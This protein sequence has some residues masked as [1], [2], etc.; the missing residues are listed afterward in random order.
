MK[1]IPDI[2]RPQPSKKKTRLVRIDKHTV[3]EVDY[4][5]SDEVVRTSYLI[6]LA[7]SKPTKRQIQESTYLI[8]SEKK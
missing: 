7:R 3:V 5:V 1:K 6:K 4:P 8:L 2:A